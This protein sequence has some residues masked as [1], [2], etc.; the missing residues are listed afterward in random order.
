[1]RS[2]L[3]AFSLLLLGN[4]SYGQGK[5]KGTIYSQDSLQPVQNALIRVI[6]TEKMVSTSKKGKFEIRLKSK[7]DSLLITSIGF[8]DLR[9][10]VNY[11]Q[12]SDS[13][14][15]AKVD[16]ILH[17]AAIQDTILD[18]L[19]IVTKSPATFR[20]GGDP[21]A[22]SEITT[23]IPISKNIT[24]Y[25]INKIFI[26][27]RKFDARN[28]VQLHIYSV[29]S[30]GLPGDE[31]LKKDIILSRE[32][33]NSKDRM[34]TIDVKDQ[35]IVLNNASFFAGVQWI[36]KRRTKQKSGPELYQTYAVPEVLSYYRDLNFD[37][38]FWFIIYENTIRVFM[39]G[40]RPAIGI[41]GNG[42][43]LNLCASAEV[44]EIPN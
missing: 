34:V 14:I 25:R 7:R 8:K 2:I 26:R 9:I 35:E 44:E 29:N 4:L 38:H 23:L 28:P 41:F 13:I 36:S 5:I 1:M 33:F 40:K 21:E 11:L 37:D 18:T 15:L 31:L 17:Q 27:G 12:G 19:G 30:Q 16:A 42:N 3:L 22:M 20:T 24:S 43:P 6:G 39:D 32:Q 10:P